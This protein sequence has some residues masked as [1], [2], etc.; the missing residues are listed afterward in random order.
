MSSG[1]CVS[2][3]LLRP[4]LQLAN[5]CSSVGL[6]EAGHFPAVM[7]VCSS[8]YKPHEL[9]RRNT[10]IQIFTQ[11]GPLF[12][13]FLMAAVFAGLDGAR[14]LPGWRWMYMCVPTL[15]L[16]TKSMLTRPAFV[17]ASPSRAPSGPHLP[18]RNFLAEQR[19][20]GVCPFHSPV[21][22]RHG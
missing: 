10:L 15:S 19:P 11:V 1:S 2:T 7:Y 20:T 6:F 3:H 9:A 18:C 5:V 4:P 22:P 16:M 12:S 21:S 14:G 8:Y 17:A 13:G